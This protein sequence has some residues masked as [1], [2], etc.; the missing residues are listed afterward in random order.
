MTSTAPT[1]GVL[2]IDLDAVAENWRRFADLGAAEAAATVK[3]NAYGL[4]AERVVARLRREGARTFFVATL[5]EAMRLLPSAGADARFYVLDGFPAAQRS[6]VDL[7]RVSPV[8]SAP[9]AVRDWLSA[10]RA[11]G[12]ASR[13]IR[14]ALQVETGMNRL[15]LTADEARSA[16]SEAA[17]GRVEIDLV[18]S[19]L[20][21][22][23]EPNHP[24]NARQR[25]AFDALLPVVR[26][27]A[28]SARISLSATGG[29]L[30]GPEHGYDLVRVGVGLFGGMP[31]ADARPAVALSAP[32]LRVWTVEPGDSSGYGASWTATRPTRLATAAIGYADGLPRALSGRGRARVGAAPAPFIG[33]VSMDLVT[34]DVTGAPSAAVGDR[35][36]FLSFD[37]SSGLTVDAMAEAANTI[38]YEVLTRLDA[39]GRLA[40][41]FID[42]GDA[43]GGPG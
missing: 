26:A 18:M 20:A 14:A 41:R 39:A 27:T 11:D 23:D 1:Q 2:E 37:K 9:E 40:R 16:L 6:E 19:H 33:R 24:M 35:A 21:A 42:R 4:G 34:L 13:P 43:D 10:A 30:L 12:D 22:A 7:R 38:G 3:A 31:F 28:P 8:L 5:V 15:G 25:E 32:L 29:A 17:D 36:E